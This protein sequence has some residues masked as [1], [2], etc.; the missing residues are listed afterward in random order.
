MIVSRTEWE[1]EQKRPPGKMK[2][3][4]KMIIDPQLVLNG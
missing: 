4:Y 1:L 2:E 3:E